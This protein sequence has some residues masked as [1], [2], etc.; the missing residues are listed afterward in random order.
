VVR[1]YSDGG[2][3]ATLAAIE[4]LLAVIFFSASIGYVRAARRAS[5]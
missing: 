1:G 2:T 4:V 5:S 3:S